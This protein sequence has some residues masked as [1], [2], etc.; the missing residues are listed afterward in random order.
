MRIKTFSE[1]EFR[2]S[3]DDLA[4]LLYRAKQCEIVF[5]ENRANQDKIFRLKKQYTDLKACYEKLRKEVIKMPV[6]WTK[7]KKA[8][9]PK[10]EKPK[11]DKPPKANKPPKGEKE[12]K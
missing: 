2:I 6:K 11:A 12:A 3:A 9:Q 10:V 4:S 5:A 8:E 1:M 7:P